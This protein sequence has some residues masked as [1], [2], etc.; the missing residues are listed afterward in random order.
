LCVNKTLLTRISKL[1][2][3]AVHQKLKVLHHVHESKEVET[4]YSVSTNQFREIQN[5]NGG[6]KR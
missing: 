1:L 2:A 3:A 4:Q 5:M 6:D